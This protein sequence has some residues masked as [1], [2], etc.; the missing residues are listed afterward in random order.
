M[1][2]DQALRDDIRRL[3]QQ[4]GETLVR[5]VG[6]DL[7]QLVEEVRGL[8]KELRDSPSEAVAERLDA[9]LGNQDIATMALLVRAFT[10][11][12][13]L[14]NVA[15]MS[16]RVGE[17]TTGTE[18]GEWLAEAVDAIGHAGLP[19]DLVESVVRR[20]ELRPVFTAHPTE[21]SR[22]SILRKLVH[23]S[24]LLEERN[25]PRASLGDQRR[26]DR[27]IGELIDQI[28]QTDELRLER[29]SPV[30]EA[31]SAIYYFD[32]LFTDVLPSVLDE[33]TV[34]VGR[35]GVHLETGDRPLRFGTWVG[36]DR[37]GNPFVTADL[38]TRIL[39]I[40]HEHGLR[41]LRRAVEKLAEELSSSIRISE[42]SRELESSLARDRHHLP[43]T[44]A[45][46]SR[47]NAEEPYRL[48]C[49]FIHERLEQTQHRVSTGS[50]HRTGVDYA[51]PDGLLDD[52][53]LM[54]AS[55][56]ANHGAAIADGVL[57]R[58][59][60]NVTAFGFHL[61]TMDIR[62]HADRHHAALVHIFDLH[63]IDYDGMARGDRVA[64]LAGELAAKRPLL[65]PATAL[66][67]VPAS[68]L[69]AFSA[70]RDA[71]ARFGEDVIESYII[72]MTRGP[73]DVLAA[74]VLAREAGLI[75]LG[76]G[77]AAIGFVPLLETVTE[78]REAGAILDALLT[79]AP[80]RQ[81]V[82]L[83]GNVQEVMLGYSDS[84]KHGGITTSQWEIY[85]AQRDLRDAAQRHGVILRL[86]H[87]RGGTVGRGG[88]PTHE[89]VLAQPW[90]VVD[91]PMK[92][93]EQGEV[94]SDK[95]ALPRLARRNLEV[96][97]ASVLEASLL[98]RTPRRTPDVLAH[99][100]EIMG[101]V[102]DAAFGAYRRLVGHPS[103]VPY[104]LTSTPVERLGAMKI[105]SRPS[106]RKGG[107]GLDD[108]RA[109]PWVF[110]WTQS[111][112]IVPGWYGVG[113]GLAAARVA[114]LGEAM[115]AMHDEWLFFRT[116]LSNV[117]MTL[118]KT[119]LGIAR[120]YVEGLVDPDH[121]GVFDL[122]VEEHDRTTAEITAV[123]GLATP[124]EAN[125]VLERTLS[126]RDRYLDPISY[127][128]VALLKR[129]RF[130]PDP[131]LERALLLTINGIATGLRNTG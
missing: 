17:L 18:G 7:L 55:L 30:D 117:S 90:G 99:W 98:H 79:V 8:T 58:L 102:S 131:D 111:R 82:D 86:F 66:P 56:R 129:A 33:F 101:V 85:K 128:Q 19:Q 35:L 75:D 13:H 105:G 124:L 1:P 14:A 116:F 94:I 122:I 81:L 2:S 10:T 27:R 107:E 50:R 46:F 91:G 69:A 4:L 41:N 97:L 114:G 25:D 70:A 36:G 43:E 104:F 6:A 16:H 22:R 72:S 78:L 64:L 88:G 32:Q 53:L 49:A 39:E 3:G 9:L 63:G 89:A 80:Y 37:D 106:R 54:D 92:I 15:E 59:I 115:R 112:Q 96:T 45:R 23:V 11:Y 77:V 130:E 126:V 28:W 60:R 20:L 29:P 57:A 118:A 65:T 74:T 31:R 120:R 93:T 42:I 61:A 87:G 67:E 48:K 95:Y 113:S 34:Q 47:L 127:L 52:L 26:I 84:N 110:G 38:T 21:A 68:V 12:F 121:H 76:G 103:L 62:E 119:D 71:H 100:D 123:T 108:L 44:F 40:Q 125:P 24:D 109:I 83:R 51:A 5:Q 73:D